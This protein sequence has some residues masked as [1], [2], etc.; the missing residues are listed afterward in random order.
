[1]VAPLEK[2]T[3]GG[4][5]AA[6]EIIAREAIARKAKSVEDSWEDFP[7]IGEQDWEMV[8]QCADERLL[9]PTVEE[10]EW[11]YALLSARAGE[12]PE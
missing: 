9:A 8:V 6:I 7:E 5:L 3:V 4:Y 11:A 1:M 2:I 10:Y 12:N